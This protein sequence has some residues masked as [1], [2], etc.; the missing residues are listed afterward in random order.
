MKKQ[1]IELGLILLCLGMIGVFSILTMEI[2]L[3]PEAEVI[4]RKSFSPLQIKM[5]ALV[6]PTIML[7]VAVVL[8]TILHQKV[9]LKVPIIEHIVGIKSHQ[10]PN[11]Q[12][13]LKYGVLGGILSGGLLS[14]VGI[15]FKPILPKEFIVLGETLQPTLTAR[16]LYGGLTEEISMRFGMMTFVTWI[17]SKILNG[18]QPIVYW[19]GIIIASAIFAIGH[20]PITYQ[21]VENPSF[22]LLSYVFI[23]NSVGGVIFGWLYWKK[24]LESA[25]IAHICTHIIMVIVERMI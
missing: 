21:A 7:I 9:N 3:P 18:T 20:F 8:G 11:L 17:A 22:G 14:L 15:I 23:G 13:I 25:F 16:F 4:L 19:I 1:N 10:L 24:G 6:N 12:N 2:P 5:L